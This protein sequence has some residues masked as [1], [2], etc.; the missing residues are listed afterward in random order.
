MAK[1]ITRRQ[2]AIL[3]IIAGHSPASIS[4][5]QEQLPETVS[6]PT[7]NRDL[8]ALVGLG[9]L[10]KTGKGRATA[11]QLSSS[12]KLFA[13]I[14]SDRYFETDPDTRDI[15]AT[16]NYD[17]L[18]MLGNA[19]LFTQHEL[20]ALEALQ[21]EYQQNIATISPTIRQKE[22]E[23]LTIDLSW[24]SS[25]IEGNTYSLLETERLFIEKREA[26]GK[27]QEEATML[28]NHKTCMDFLLNPKAPGE[29]LNLA[30]LEEIHS[31]LIKNL[32]VSHNLRKRLVGIT[33]TAYKPPDNQ[34]QIKQAVE[35]MCRAINAKQ[36]GF[37]QALLAVALIS[38]IQPFEDGNK[39]TARMVSNAVLIANRACPLS[40]RSVE[41]LEYKKAM[42]IFYEQNNLS[43]FKEI[44]T[45]QIEFAVKNYFQ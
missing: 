17:L 13:P 40:Y 42:L 26:E 23:R 21:Q 16:F 14:D 11:Y 19:P 8:A 10:T 41:S 36:N 28:L 34:H 33:G 43:A 29:T 22:L 44:F 24:K 25:Q 20:T 18:A 12:Y 5:I 27:S 38:Y 9:H 35:E 37:E 30:A 3:E 31:L 6:I 1:T 4:R 7:L 2:Q 32:G 39:R 15:V 45:Q